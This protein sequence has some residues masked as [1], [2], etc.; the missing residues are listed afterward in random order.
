MMKKMI[1]LLVLL[2]MCASLVLPVMAS[3]NQFVPSIGYKDGPGIDDADLDGEDVDQCVIVT[4]VEQAKKKET[5]ISQEDRDLL[6]EIYEKLVDG[7]MTLPVDGDYVIRDLVD[8][9]FEYEDCR[10][11]E[12]HGNKPEKL[13][14]E[15]TTLTITFDM[16]VKS[17]EKIIVMVYIDGQWVPV[18]DVTN[19]GD[20]TL[21]VVF[22]DICPVV[23]L[24]E[25]TKADPTP[26]TGD[27]AGKWL[28]LAVGLMVISAAAIIVLLTTKSRKTH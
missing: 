13:K 12:E 5:D 28:I 22:E 27:A 14:Q 2:V 9:S 11:I 23:F 21:T 6:Q 3:Q 18:E 16:G 20:G 17:D 7:S 4:T 8:V 15:G 19:N 26:P 25:Q 24:T 1:C 10:E